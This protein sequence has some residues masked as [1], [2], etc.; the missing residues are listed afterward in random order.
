MSQATTEKTTGAAAGK[1]LLCK[2]FT[3]QNISSLVDPQWLLL[4]LQ[5]SG[6]QYQP[7]S[8]MGLQAR[9]VIVEDIKMFI[10]NYYKANNIDI[11]TDEAAAKQINTWFEA[12]IIKSVGPYAVAQIGAISQERLQEIVANSGFGFSPFGQQ[13]GMGMPGF[14]M[15]MPGFGM[16]M[17]GFGQMNPFAQQSMGMPMW[18]KK[19]D[20]TQQKTQQP[21]MGFNPMMMNGMNPMMFGQ[22]MPFGMNQGFGFP[23]MMGGI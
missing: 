7:Q 23:G 4:Q 1:K 17:P 2:T 11:E 13:M 18:N 10:A 19:A 20:T 22:Q 14:G 5:T 16:Q 9:A 8:Y 3:E 6:I 15:Q 21:N 12:A